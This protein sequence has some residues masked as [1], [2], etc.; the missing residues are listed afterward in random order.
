MIRKTRYL[1]LGA[2]INWDTD[3]LKQ[4]LETMAQKGWKLTKVG[5]FLTFKR[6]EPE[7][8]QFEIDYFASDLTWTSNN[9]PIIMDYKQLCEDSGWTYRGN[10]QQLFIFSA[11]ANQE[12][13]PLQ[14]DEELKRQILLSIAFKHSLY[15]L[16]WPLTSLFNHTLKIRL[17]TLTSYS[18]TIS[19]IINWLLFIGLL[20]YSLL[21]LLQFFQIKGFLKLKSVKL[22]PKLIRNTFSLI[23]SLS[24]F[25]LILL[26]FSLTFDNLALGLAL[27]FEFITIGL[28]TYTLSII[29]KRVFNRKK[30]LFLITI[31]LLLTMMISLHG[32]IFSIFSTPLTK[33][34]DLHLEYPILN[35]EPLQLNQSREIYVKRQ[36]SFVFSD[37]LV[38]HDG[39]INFDY[40]QLRNTPFTNQIIKII[41][42]EFTANYQELIPSEQQPFLYDIYHTDSHELIGYIL[43]HDQNFLIFQAEAETLNNPTLKNNVET[44][45]NQLSN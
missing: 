30:K 20:T 6:S 4:K 22:L 26:V 19:L 41:L 5:T 18:S 37:Y 7:N 25:L 2:Q 35:E 43:Y 21:N 36:S 29:K 27:L 40:F 45:F 44:L 14:T 34:S 31:S 23:I 13:T 39:H 9:D 16:V 3:Y 33:Q 15:F 42:N 12:I 10:A 32:M 17:D 28:G 1:F 11:P 24:L 8:L 38:I